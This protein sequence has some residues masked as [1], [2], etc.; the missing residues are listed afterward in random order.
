[1]LD[2]L[3]VALGQNRWL[4]EILE[5]FEEI[6]LPDAWLVAGSI[7]QTVWNL[8]CGQP[9]HLRAVH[10]RRQGRGQMDPPVMLILRR[11]RRPPPA[12]RAGLQSRQFHADTGDAEDG[13]AVVADQLA[14]EADQDRR[15]GREPRPLHDLSDG[16]GRGA[17]TDVPGDPGVDR[18]TAGAART[19]VTGRSGQMRQP[20]TAKLRLDEHK[21]ASFGPA[22]PSTLPF[23]LVNESAAIEFRC[24]RP[25]R[26][27]T[28]RP[29]T[30]VSGKCR[31]RCG[32]CLIGLRR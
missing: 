20:T 28:S 22:G 12:P 6:A 2:D 19:S 18:P 5:R 26:G 13:G 31:L 32:F 30:S 1:V 10:Q 29:T 15:Q 8:G 16:R 14:R 3:E 17:A 25:P 4:R 21:A 11:Q 7:A 24:R 9:R 23:W 27:A